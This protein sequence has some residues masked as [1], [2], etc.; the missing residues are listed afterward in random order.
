M[1]YVITASLVILTLNASIAQTKLG[2]KVNTSLIAYR[3]DQKSNSMDEL[4]AGPKPLV[5]SATLFADIPLSKNY[6]FSTGIGYISKRVNLEVMQEEGLE[7]QDK[8][9]N[10]QYV[11]LPATIKLYTNEI[12]LDKKLYFQFGPLFEI[13]IHSKEKDGQIDV[14]SKSQFFDI[15]LLFAT[16][17]QIQ[18]APQTAILLGINYTRGLVN[19]VS[20]PALPQMDPVIKNDLY[21]IDVAIKF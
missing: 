13:N 18:V 10:L 4:G 8:S 15:S 16:G 3:I 7:V 19:I 21:G 9:Y 17:I 20:K 1:K 6:F 11:Q 12:A 14:M 2:L 5:L